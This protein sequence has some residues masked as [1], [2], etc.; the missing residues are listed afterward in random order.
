MMAVTF[1]TGG[2]HPGMRKGL[3]VL[4]QLSDEDVDWLA[5]TGD[6]EKVN[7]GATLIERGR[8]IDNIYI[9]LEGRLGVYLAADAS[10]Q[11]ALLR[12]GEI[13]GEMS[14]VDA[15][16]PSASVRADEDSLV[17]RVPRAAIQTKIEADQAFAARIFRSVA[18]FL[19]DRLRTTTV[20]LAQ[21]QG[22][23]RAAQDWEDGALDGGSFSGN[24]LD[25]ML[26][27][28]KKL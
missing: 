21:L 10:R 18:M 17:L 14:F 11:V 19:S 7:A 16:P 9:L 15:S 22:G 20:Q 26:T 24:R 6:V 1:Q 4:G 27:I 2:Q 12:A 8:Q 23:P 28:L 25:S 13:V 5:R 3:F